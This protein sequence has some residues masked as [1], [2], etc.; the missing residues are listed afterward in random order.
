MLTEGL[1]IIPVGSHLNQKLITFMEEDCVQVMFLFLLQKFTGSSA[2][3]THHQV[4]LALT[5]DE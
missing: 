5:I 1:D 2:S 4:S 3:T